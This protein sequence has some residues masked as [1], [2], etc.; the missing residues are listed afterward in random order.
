LRPKMTRYRG[1]RIRS[2]TWARMHKPSSMHRVPDFGPECVE[3]A[4]PATQ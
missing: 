2:A 4:R 1:D 3:D